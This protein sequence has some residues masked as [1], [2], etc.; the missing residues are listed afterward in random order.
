MKTILQLVQDPITKQAALAGNP[1][2]FQRER[3]RS[4]RKNET[5]L[6]TKPGP[7]YA[8]RALREGA[9]AGSSEFISL[10]PGREFRPVLALQTM[11]RAETTLN[12]GRAS[13]RW[14]NRA[15]NCRH[16]GHA[17]QLRPRRYCRNHGRTTINGRP[18]DSIGRP[19]TELMRTPISSS[20]SQVEEVRRLASRLRPALEKSFQLTHI[21]HQ[22]VQ[23]SVMVSTYS[24]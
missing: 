21:A 19:V 10:A 6:R 17:R 7:R 8:H 13:H 18:V 20:K 14:T 24:V 22:C 16:P 5:P 3:P 4:G 9:Y 1:A 12:R 15:G 11:D 23:D 2:R